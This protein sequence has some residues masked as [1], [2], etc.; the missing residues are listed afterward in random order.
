MNLIINNLPISGSAL[1]SGWGNNYNGFGLL[2]CSHAVAYGL[3]LFPLVSNGGNKL[4][5]SA[6][7]GTYPL[8]SSSTSS[9]NAPVTISSTGYVYGCFSYSTS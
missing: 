9:F 7:N 4:Y 5:F 2:Q 3:Q 6:P 1:P 8:Q